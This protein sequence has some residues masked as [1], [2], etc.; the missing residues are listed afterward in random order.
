MYKR[1]KSSTA[2]A[3]IMGLAVLPLGV[4]ADDSDD[5]DNKG[6]V[7]TGN[8]AQLPAGRTTEFHG[9]PAT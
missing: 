4:M 9:N 5:D 2:I 7:L 8:C 6:F 3:L 1:N